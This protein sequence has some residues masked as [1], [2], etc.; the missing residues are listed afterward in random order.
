MK[1]ILNYPDRR[2]MLLRKRRRIICASF[3][4]MQLVPATIA[5]AQISSTSTRVVPDTIWVNIFFESI[6][7]LA[8]NLGFKPL[9]AIAIRP[10]DFELRIWTG[11]GI[12]G[13]GGTIVR[14]I[15]HKWSAFILSDPQGTRRI[16]GRYVEPSAKKAAESIDWARI[17]EKLEREGI[18]NIRDDSEIPHCKAVLDGVSYV[19]EIAREDYYRTYMV[20]NPQIQRS[21]DGDRFLHIMSI[22]RDAFGGTSADDLTKLPTGEVLTVASFSH[23]VTNSGNPLGRRF[24][25]SEYVV[26][27]IPSEDSVIRVSPEEGY[28]QRINLFIPQCY[29]LPVP[30]RYIANQLEGEVVM[31]LFIHPD[32]ST[33]AARAL[34]G[35]PVLAE[36]ALR[37]ALKWKFVPMNIGDKIR[38]TVI[39]IRYQKKWVRYPWII[40]KKGF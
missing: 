29:E 35:Q 7:K 32:G 1:D 23:E 9:R 13:L 34:L 30:Q 6:D 36:N 15:D 20:A 3:L 14:R 25:G 5:I 38:R 18:E 8:I 12:S 26:G 40:E 24:E 31:E 39:S 2:S 4:A 11:F 21:E 27:T 10:G 19:V 22:F 17:W 28:A 37:A 16:N 33:S